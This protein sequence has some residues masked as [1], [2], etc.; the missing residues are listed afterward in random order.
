MRHAR[1]TAPHVSTDRESNSLRDNEE[2]FNRYKIRPRILVNVANVDTS[3]TIF[4]EKVSLPLGFAPVA[5]HKL[6][7]PDGE[8][9]TSRAAAKHGICMGL[10][11]S[12]TAS[13][14]EVAVE[15]RGNPM[16]MQMCILQDRRITERVVKRAEGKETYVS[17]SLPALIVPTPAAGY[18]ALF[19]SI[20]VPMLGRR[21]NEYRNGFA[22]PADIKLPN[23][24]DEDLPSVMGHTDGESTAGQQYGASTPFQPQKGM[25][26]DWH[27]NK[28]TTY[29]SLARL[30]HDNSMAQIHDQF[31]YLVERRDLS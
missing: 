12:P 4:G 6:A 18:K 16:A 17:L 1:Y 21:L 30:G 20:D 24:L 3:S 11:S 19:I 15:R 9:G 23:I 13:L 7:H 26:V 5:T 28:C 27:A 2:A 14:E 29:R 22:L 31:R 10:S 25:C 8:V